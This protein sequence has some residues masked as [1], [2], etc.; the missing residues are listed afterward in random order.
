MTWKVRLENEMGTQYMDI[1]IGDQEESYDPTTGEK[2]SEKQK[3]LDIAKR[4]NERFS[5][6][7]GRDPYVLAEIYK[8][9]SQDDPKS[10]AVKK[11]AK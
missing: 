5:E 8:V 10:K 4:Q 6:S 7:Y 11:K 1:T 3:V 2:I 9:G